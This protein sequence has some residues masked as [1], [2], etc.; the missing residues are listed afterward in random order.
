MALQHPPRAGLRP[1][2]GSGA[3]R[4]PGRSRAAAREPPP[5]GRALAAGVAAARTGVVHDGTG[6]AAVALGH[7]RRESP[8]AVVERGYRPS[9]T[10]EAGPLDDRV[11]R[12][13]RAVAAGIIPFL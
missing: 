3:R 11:V 7:P 10:R 8:S 13:T 5:L 9:M 4:A 2:C 12:S 1:E 6:R